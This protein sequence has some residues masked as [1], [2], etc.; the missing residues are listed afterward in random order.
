MT[1]RTNKRNRTDRRI[2]ETSHIQ[3]HKDL[4]IADGAFLVITINNT[5]PG[6]EQTQS[7][8]EISL[9]ERLP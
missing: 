7:T 8:G 9:L 5:R 6:P 4:N 2:H 1:K 3:Q